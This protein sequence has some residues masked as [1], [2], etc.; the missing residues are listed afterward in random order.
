MGAKCQQLLWRDRG[1][2]TGKP[3]AIPGG[4]TQLGT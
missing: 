2:S 3:G 1:N 4:V